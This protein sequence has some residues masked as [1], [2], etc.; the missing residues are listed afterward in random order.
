MGLIEFIVLC[1]NDLKVDN[2]DWMQY[3]YHHT[4]ILL[5]TKVVKV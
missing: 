4:L 2:N 3:K 5:F 1:T